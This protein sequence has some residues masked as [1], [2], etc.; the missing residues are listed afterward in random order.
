MT[1]A[2]G[3]LLA[4]LRSDVTPSVAAPHAPSL[5]ATTGR[6]IGRVREVEA[7]SLL[8]ASPDVRLVS[9]TGAGGTGK[10]RLAIEVGR[11]LAPRYPGGVNFMALAAV[12][13]VAVLESAIAQELGAK[14]SAGAALPG[15]VARAFSESHRGA[16]LLVLD[17]FEQLVDASAL[18]AQLLAAVPALELLVTSRTVLRLSSEHEYAVLPLAVPDPTSR[19]SA[20][21]LESVPA[22]ALF[23]ERARAANP[24]FAIGP[25]NAAAVAAIV[26][27]LNGLP[28]A[29]ELAAARIRAFT[30]QTLL[31]KLE[32]RL[33][34]L[35][36][37]ARD[38]PVRQQTL[39]NTIDWSH[40]LLTEP[41][42]RLLRRLAVFV[43]GGTL[44][45]IEAVCDAAQDLGVEVLDGV[46]SLVDK[47]LAQQRA[48]PDGETLITMF[49]TIREYAAESLTTAGEREA[50]AR[51]HA[52]FYLL[53]AEDGDTAMSGDERETWLRRFTVEHDN[54][55][56][57]FDWAVGHGN[58]D[59]A[60]RLGL[61]LFRFW[62][63]RE[64]T[65]EGRTRLR[66]LVGL[67]ADAV[68]PQWARLLMY[69]G[70]LAS[71]LGDAE[72]S[73]RTLLASLALSRQLGDRA[74]EAITLNNLGVSEQLRGS[75]DSARRHI[76]EALTLWRRAND[77]SSVGRT[78]NNLGTIAMAQGAFERCRELNAEALA[79]FENEGDTAS[80]ALT[81][82]AMGDTSRATGRP[83]DAE[84]HY[85]RALDT[86]QSLDDQLGSAGAQLD[87]GSLAVD[88]GL[89]PQGRVALGRAVD[90]FKTLG[91]KRGLARA[92]E[93]LAI[94]LASEGRHEAALRLAGGAAG[95][96]H[97][98]GLA[99]SG[100]ERERV[101][102][103]IGPLRQARGDQAWRAGHGLDEAALLDEAR[104]ILTV[105]QD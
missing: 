66:Q 52:A 100:A 47:N 43:G 90:G 105:S 68:S 92:L 26:A 54:F 58:I 17:N 46:S 80:V 79:I 56:A 101:S 73:E 64:H 102:Q 82:Q 98:M 45:A 4:A 60:Q 50:T 85:R 97:R 51:A 15:A 40:G 5:P 74:S 81:L 63:W 25:D 96:R 89:L 99:A 32:R 87:I 53:L 30:P 10:T 83:D 91:Y 35:T 57:A 94:A 12:T 22:V 37:G 76:E 2:A 33:Q 8:L 24:A 38:L 59:W 27:R 55:R 95:L 71:E 69:A 23:A 72:D 39:R 13:D 31:P 11:A 6:L 84:Q 104:D 34:L 48:L 61:A 14:L 75:Y 67:R 41:E 44:E 49:E 86:W 78:L 18:L 3:A 28:L 20:S 1:D 19:L 29:L 93:E 70:I 9:L 7:I 42:Q 88:R 21:A 36:S 77:T 103:L 16:T 65:A 62:Q